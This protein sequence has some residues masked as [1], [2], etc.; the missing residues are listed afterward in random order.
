MA[1]VAGNGGLSFYRTS[2]ATGLLSAVVRTSRFRTSHLGVFTNLSTGPSQATNHLG[3]QAIHG[4]FGFP[5]NLNRVTRS[6]REWT[7]GP[8]QSLCRT[9]RKGLLG[10]SCGARPPGLKSQRFERGGIS[11]CGGYTLLCCSWCCF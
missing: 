6:A 7:T 9:V 4:S 2:A 10:R 1:D 5:R 11:P 3:P 8:G